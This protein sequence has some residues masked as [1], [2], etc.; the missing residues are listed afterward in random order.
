DFRLAVCIRGTGRV[1]GDEVRFGDQEDRTVG[2]IKIVLV[3]GHDR[4]VNTLAGVEI[5]VLDVGLAVVVAREAGDDL[6][7]GRDRA[8]IVAYVTDR[9]TVGG[10]QDSEIGGGEVESRG[11]RPVGYAQRASCD[12]QD[13]TH[14]RRA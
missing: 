2:V 7:T 13:T 14:A 1:A 3:G 6:M 5:I 11:A 10:A 9:A 12:Q 4:E 8:D